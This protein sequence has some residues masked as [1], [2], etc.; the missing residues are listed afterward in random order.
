MSGARF[1]NGDVLPAEVA[2]AL[3]VISSS[4][5]TAMPR[6]SSTACRKADFSIVYRRTSEAARIDVS[7]APPW[8]NAISPNPVPA[9][10]CPT[11]RN[12]FGSGFQGVVSGRGPGRPLAAHTSTS[13]AAI[14]KYSSPG[15]PS[16]TT[17]SPDDRRSSSRRGTTRSSA[18][19]GS[20]RK[21][22][23][24]PAH[25][26]E[27]GPRRRRSKPIV[28]FLARASETG[29]CLFLTACAAKEVLHEQEARK[30]VVA[31]K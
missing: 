9:A 3:S 27:T 18:A 4:R 24:G 14:R 30:L 5:A 22:S 17:I 28:G 7:L 23:I 25:P 26:V 11:S 8:S 19:D 21:K 29:A 16:Q 31:D 20:D 12:R 13:P 15:S 2:S 6:C 10:R 1:A